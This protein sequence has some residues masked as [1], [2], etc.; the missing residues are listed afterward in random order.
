MTSSNAVVWMTSL[1]NNVKMQLSDAKIY[2]TLIG[3]SSE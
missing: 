3:D 1:N 2:M